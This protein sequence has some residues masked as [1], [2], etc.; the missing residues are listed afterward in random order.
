MHLQLDGAYVEQLPVEEEAGECLVFVHLDGLLQLEPHYDDFAV[1][2]GLTLWL[3]ITNSVVIVV[4]S[5]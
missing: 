5:C 2:D 1:C 3:I 4:R